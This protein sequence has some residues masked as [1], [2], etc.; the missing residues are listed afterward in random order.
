MEWSCREL[1]AIS[2]VS[3]EKKITFTNCRGSPLLTPIN[4]PALQYEWR[5]GLRAVL[6]ST[7]HGESRNVHVI[8]RKDNSTL[9]FQWSERNFLTEHQQW[10][11]CCDRLRIAPCCAFPKPTPLGSVTIYY[12]SSHADRVDNVPLISWG[13]P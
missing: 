8:E 10:C 1:F 12:T 4:P 2:A 9:H 6:A 5:L 11:H 7:L 3:P 13:S